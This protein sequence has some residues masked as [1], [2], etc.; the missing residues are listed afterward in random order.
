MKL[1]RRQSKMLLK[2][3]P[4]LNKDY[5]NN[6][7]NKFRQS[8]MDNSG[9][10]KNSKLNKDLKDYNPDMRSSTKSPGLC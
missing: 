4:T 3:V 8:I 6:S 5:F 7:I 9:K 2:Q 10:S 1:A